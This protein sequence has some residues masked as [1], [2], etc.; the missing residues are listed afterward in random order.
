MVFRLGRQ[1]QVGA[2]EGAKV[3]VLVVVGG[4]GGE[5][6]RFSE[7]EFLFDLLRVQARY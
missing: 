1:R 6:V 2:R 4:G 7:V 5:L 3:R